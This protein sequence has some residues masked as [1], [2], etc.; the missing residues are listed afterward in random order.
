MTL[1]AARLPYGFALCIVCESTVV[2]ALNEV[3][4]RRAATGVL[5]RVKQHVVH[6]LH[7]VLHKHLGLVPAERLGHTRG[8]RK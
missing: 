4:D 3:I 1:L 5:K 7:V 2:V 6:F 8:S